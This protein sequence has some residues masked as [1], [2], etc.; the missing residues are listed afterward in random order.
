M[1]SLRHLEEL[2]LVSPIFH[3]WSGQTKL[4]ADDL[5]L[6]D[7]GRL[8][9]DKV[10]QLGSKNICDPKLLTE[11]NTMKTACRRK[12]LSYGMKFLGSFIVPISKL[13]DIIGELERI[14]IEF[15]NSKQTFLSCYYDALE[16]WITENKEFESAIRAGSLSVEEVQKRISFDY[17]IITVAPAPVTGSK[18]KLESAVGGLGEELIKEVISEANDFYYGLLKGKQTCAVKSLARLA[19]LR[20]KLD[21]LSFL[22][23]SFR[24][25]VDM[26]TNTLSLMKKYEDKKTIPAPD[27]YIIHAAALIMSSRDSIEAH[28]NGDQTLVEQTAELCD[29]TALLTTLRQ[30]PVQAVAPLSEKP[31]VDSLPAVDLP[32]QVQQLEEGIKSPVFDVNS[33]G[34]DFDDLDAFLAQQG[35]E[36][37]HEPET[38]LE[39]TRSSVS[40]FDPDETDEDVVNSMPILG[41]TIGD[42]LSDSDFGGSGIS[43]DSFF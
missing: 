23:S 22:D 29:D 25:L 37:I 43:D 34:D 1:S 17:Q 8:P 42:S 39:D 16:E 21:G 4:E 2:C 38:E 7:G 28:T 26:L 40:S 6:G 19:N 18:E 15:N 32:S 3:I 31:A 41:G 10:A 35:I 13:D 9:P 20:N 27:V 24:P 33:V 14:K 36:V 11:F 12:L 5:K 30:S